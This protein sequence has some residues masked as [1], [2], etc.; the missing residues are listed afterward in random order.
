MSETTRVYEANDVVNPAV[1]AVLVTTG[2]INEG[3]GTG[4]VVTVLAQAYSSAAITLAVRLKNT[5][6]VVV[7]TYKFICPANNRG[8]W[9]DTAAA[10]QVPNDFSLEIAA[11]A[12]I[13]GTIHAAL[14]LGLVSSY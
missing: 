9:G 12:A 14:F 3:G 4:S 6:G 10:F 5:S 1:N 7:R 11:P 13:T 2:A 8:F